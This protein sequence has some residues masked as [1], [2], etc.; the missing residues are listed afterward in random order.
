V[1]TDR[2]RDA[3]LKDALDR[4][5]SEYREMEIAVAARDGAPRVVRVHVPYMMQTVAIVDRPRDFAALRPRHQRRLLRVKE[6][7]DRRAPSAVKAFLHEQFHDA[8]GDERL[9]AAGRGDAGAIRMLLQAAVDSGLLPEDPGSADL[10][11]WLKRYGIGVDCSAL[12]QHALERLLRVTGAEGTGDAALGF[13]RSGWVYRDVTASAGCD[14]FCHVPT[15]GD[16][17][18]GDVL[19]SRGHVRVVFDLE[20]T[21]EGAA[22]LHLIE[23]ISMWGVPCGQTTADIDIGPRRL[24]VKYPAPDR[25]IGE[26]KPLRLG[27]G[28]GAFYEASAERAYVLGR[29][30]TLNAG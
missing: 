23:S 20:R 11:A 19:V 22:I 8:D 30:R 24:Q 27:W 12:A 4:F 2:A 18:L 6:A 15:P 17:R 25:P 26:Q 7:R 5:L 29:L 13:L 1:H 3:L 9:V 10:R 28:S 14:L 16:A 21:P